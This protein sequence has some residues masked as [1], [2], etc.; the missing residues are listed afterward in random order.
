M[1]IEAWKLAKASQFVMSPDMKF[2]PALHWIRLADGYL[3][4]TD[5]HAMIQILHEGP[6]GREFYFR[7][8][9]PLHK[10]ATEV[11]FVLDAKSGL[12]K[13]EV[14]G[15]K[16]RVLGL[17]SKWFEVL[18]D[19]DWRAQ[20]RKYHWPAVY[21]AL[22][23][24]RGFESL[25]DRRPSIALNAAILARYQYGDKESAGVCLELGKKDTDPVYV[26]PHKEN[27]HQ[28]WE[29]VLAPMRFFGG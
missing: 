22:D 7:P 15:G 12:V 3:Q 28:G 4:A 14:I 13:G 9:H 16:D 6:G 25:E 11:H 21:R 10:L 26:R 27:E 29:G 18:V 17:L 24:V 20:G 5:G 2:K 1:Q 8:V 19:C 23:S